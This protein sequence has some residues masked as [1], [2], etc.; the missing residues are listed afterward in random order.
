MLSFSGDFI[1]FGTPYLDD[2]SCVNM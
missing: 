2:F 1:V